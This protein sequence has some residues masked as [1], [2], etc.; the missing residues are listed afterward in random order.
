MDD[1][2]KITDTN[3]ITNAM[4]SQEVREA[5]T[6]GSTAVVSDN[7]ITTDN[8]QNGA[9][10][11]LKL[12]DIL[13]KN[14]TKE[15]L[16]IDYT[17]SY[18]GA[19]YAN[20][21]NELTTSTSSTYK[22]A[23]ISLDNNTIYYFS[24]FNAYSFQGIIVVDE[25]DDN[26]IVFKSPITST[27]NPIEK[28]SLIFR[29]NKSGLKAYI[30]MWASAGGVHPLGTILLN[31]L[32]KL[33]DAKL[34]ELPKTFNAIRTL[35]NYYANNSTSASLQGEPGLSSLS[36]MNVKI[37]KLSKGTKY[38][39]KADNLWGICGL[40]ITNE[41]W[42]TS[43]KSSDSNVA[44]KTSFTYSFTASNNGYALLSYGTAGSTTLSASITIDEIEN[45]FA[46][47]KWALIG[48]SLTDANSNPTVKKYYEYVQDDLGLSLQ[49]LGQS[50]CGYKRK[51]NSGNNFVEQSLLIDSDAD[52]VTLFGSWNDGGEFANIGDDTDTTTDT[53]LGSVYV[54]INNIITN[55]PHTRIGVILPTPWYTVYPGNITTTYQKYIDGIKT[56]AQRH[57]VPV[58]D[59]FHESNLYPWIDGFKSSFFVSGDGVHPNSD[60]NKQFAY[61]IEEFIKSL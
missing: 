36:N 38:T 50:G 20:G 22:Y 44:T 25:S 55:N 18:Q 5:L 46:N 29:T 49:N 11:V 40:I 61:K 41:D 17:A 57:C 43:Y 58:L 53:V 45:R 59:L 52:I 13:G 54:A 1:T 4:L 34:N 19:K 30:N 39:V 7:S 37:Y 35:E 24:G 28:T 33:N 15:Y 26:A 48:D 42:T 9:I 56:I 47:M 51:Y 21:D 6:G 23:E 14:F 31:N 10:T 3:V 2:I 27:S 8:I 16:N 60:G 32:S 12:D